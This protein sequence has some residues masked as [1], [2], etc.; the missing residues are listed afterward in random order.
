MKK[1]KSS[2]LFLGFLV[3]GIFL[4]PFISKNNR[5]TKSLQKGIEK[6]Q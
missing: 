6:E 2:L 4:I 3:A 5:E 1:V